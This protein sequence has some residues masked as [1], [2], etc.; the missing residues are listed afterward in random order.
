MLKDMQQWGVTEE[1]DNPVVLIWKKNGDLQFC[2]DYRKLN[3]VIKT[4]RF[5]LLQTDDTLDML[6]GTK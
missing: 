3:D 6:A 2:I 4:G 5:P 1:S